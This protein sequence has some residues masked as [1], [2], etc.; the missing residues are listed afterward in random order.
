[1]SEARDGTTRKH[2]ALAMLMDAIVERSVAVDADEA[3]GQAYADQADWDP[4]GSTGYVFIVLRPVRMQAWREANEIPGR[5]L[6]RN[7]TWLH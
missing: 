1:M 5:T 4:R 2:D 7:G 3:L 6:M